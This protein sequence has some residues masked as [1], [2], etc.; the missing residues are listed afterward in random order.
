MGG[1]LVGRRLN[2]SMVT[3]KRARSITNVGDTEAIL[4]LFNAAP[5]LSGESVDSESVYGIPA[6]LNG[7]RL[8]SQSTARIPCH[9]IA[10]GDNNSRD[11]AYDH[12]AY[13]LLN[14]KANS[15]QTS[16]TVRQAIVNN[17]I[18]SGNGY[19]LIERQGIIPTAIYPLDS[20]QV[21]VIYEQ[22]E[23]GKL[24]GLY[25]GVNANGEQ[26]IIPEA[27]MIHIKNVALH[28]GIEGLSIVDA[29]KQT[30]GLQIA[31]TKFKAIYYKQGSHINRVL[32]IPGWLTEEQAEQLRNSMASLHQGVS[33]AHRLAIL[34]GG[35]DLQTLPVSAEEMELA[36]SAELGLNDIAGILSIPVSLLGGRNSISYG[37]LEQDQLFLLSYTLDPWLVNL[38]TEFSTK[39]LRPSERRNYL[40]E[41]ERKALLRADTTAEINNL[42][43]QYNQGLLSWEEV[44]TYLSK[45]TIKEGTFKGLPEPKPEPEPQP[46]Q[47]PEPQHDQN[48]QDQMERAIRLTEATLNRI[49]TRLVKNGKPLQEQVEVIRESLPDFAD[50]V[51]ADLDTEELKQVLP[52]QRAE[53]YN[54]WNTAKLAKSLWKS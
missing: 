25:Y 26:V 21:Y 42:I 17:A 23:Y 6:F 33:Q 13:D 52:E 2:K 9:V 16:F 31:I 10:L 3:I 36:A 51:I 30:L 32:K 29:L 1:S 7:S 14:F 28:N 34:M 41:H 50:T 49:K 37:S 44:R 8:I 15:F 12:P 54:R 11:K 53:V 47:M 39:L 18:W 45:S 40:I 27:D 22:D 35:A 43:N 24:I 38:E 20:R 46:E 5:S 4:K 48:M 19:G